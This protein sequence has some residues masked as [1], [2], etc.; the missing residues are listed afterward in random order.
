MDF[1]QKKSPG[2]FPQTSHWQVKSLGC[3]LFRPGSSCTGSFKG[4][5]AIT[6]ECDMQ[7]IC[8]KTLHSQLT[9][10]IHAV[11]M[12]S[13]RGCTISRANPFMASTKAPLTNKNSQRS[14]SLS[15]WVWRLQ[16]IFIGWRRR[17]T[18]FTAGTNVSALRLW[19]FGRALE[20][21]SQRSA[22]Q[23]SPAERVNRNEFIITEYSSFFTVLIEV[24]QKG[25]E[26]KTIQKCL[27]FFQ[28]HL[29]RAFQWEERMFIKNN[30][31]KMLF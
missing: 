19:N 6:Q 16:V 30:N 26:L 25:R 9:A 13:W 27:L 10:H 8:L 29:L 5:P 21:H 15:P 11:F 14:G 4:L 1:H 17:W 7:G 3:I 24:F 28:G 31:I 12:L 2:F 20:T 23:S 18:C 22:G